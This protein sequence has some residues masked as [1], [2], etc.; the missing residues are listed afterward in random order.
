MVNIPINIKIQKYMHTML[1][2]EIAL[3][4]SNTR[5]HLPL[6]LRTQFLLFEAKILNQDITFAIDGSAKELS[7]TIISKRLEQI[8]AKSKNPVVYVREQVTAYNRKRLIEHKVPFI[9]PGSQMYLPMLG[10]DLREHLEKLRTKPQW[11]SPSAQAVLIHILLHPALQTVFTLK[12]ISQAL[13]MTTMTSSRSFDELESLG[14]AQKAIHNKKRQIIVGSQKEDLWQKALPYLRSPVKKKIFARVETKQSS[15]LVAGL[16]AL[17]HYS[18]L[19]DPPHVIIALSLD[20]WRKLKTLNHIVEQPYVDTDSKEIEIWRYHPTLFGKDGVVDRLSLF[21]S[22]K[23]FEDERV[24]M[25]LKQ[26]MEEV[27]WSRD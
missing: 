2:N 24:E 12:E 3:K 10:L 1:G 22:L 17:A 5:Q 18:N 11:L 7:P 23:D 9:V 15:G 21:L 8:Q 19:D 25:S 20:D 26:M 13:G 14:L 4:P 27:S 16:S 6:L